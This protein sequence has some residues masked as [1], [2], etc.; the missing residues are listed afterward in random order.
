MLSLDVLN[1]V[2]MISQSHKEQSIHAD[3]H[4]STGTNNDT[5]DAFHRTTKTK[6]SDKA[7]AS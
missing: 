2:S 4:N 3:R 6:N 7:G 5:K 1:V